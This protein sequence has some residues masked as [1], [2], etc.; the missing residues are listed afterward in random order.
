M[1]AQIDK[2]KAIE[3]LR[4]SP[5]FHFS[6]GSKELFHSNF[7][8]WIST[9]KTSDGEYV[10][11]KIFSFAEGDFEVLREKNNLDFALCR[12]GDSCGKDGYLM[13]VENKL[14]S[15]P[16]SSQ[17]ERYDK[18]KNG[19]TQQTCRVLLTLMEDFPDKSK[20]ESENWKIVTYG[21][22]C[23]KLRGI[24]KL[25]PNDYER[26]IISDYCDFTE[27]LVCL[28]KHNLDSES[29]F[30][31]KKNEEVLGEL[32]IDD[33][34]DKMR[35]AKMAA[36][37]KSEIP[38]GFEIRTGYGHHNAMV[39]I[40]YSK[41]LNKDTISD[42]KTPNLVL[43]IQGNK[44]S[45][46]LYPCFYNS[47]EECVSKYLEK[48]PEF[49]S[50]DVNEFRSCMSAKSHIFVNGKTSKLLFGKFESKGDAAMI[51]QSAIISPDATVGDIIEYIK[52]DLAVMKQSYK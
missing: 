43:Q 7:L 42:V 25:V 33:L 11:R 22:L 10:I 19:L 30:L 49:L 45:H 24:I 34:I 16:D 47:P 52:G 37:L 1:T 32:R 8:A 2:Q 15:V 28:A 9:L 21:E 51:Y 31:S 14:K 40:W 46:C 23:S 44:Y 35:F 18:D 12:R 29:Y 38:E 50:R 20:I 27:A 3:I 36:V 6:L 4:K 48:Y 39:E 17:L 26:E 13:V 5:M 41:I